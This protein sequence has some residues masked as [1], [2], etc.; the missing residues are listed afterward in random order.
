MPRDTPYTGNQVAAGG[1]FH[2]E[3]Y[4]RQP[5]GELV[6]ACVMS[7]MVPPSVGDTLSLTLPGG[8]PD[9]EYRV[10]HRMWHI[11]VNES[12]QGW[13]VCVHVEAKA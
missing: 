9:W 13:V 8:A 5:G 11:D 12:G 4:L 1:P 3:C 7:A 2:I 6:R 10:T